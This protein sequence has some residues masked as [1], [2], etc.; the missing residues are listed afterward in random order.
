[1]SK[2]KKW[3]SQVVKITLDPQLGSR[4]RLALRLLA[5]IGTFAGL[6]AH[7]DQIVQATT[8]FQALLAI[9]VVAPTPTP[10][11]TPDPSQDGA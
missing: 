4:V 1:M 10:D 11:P 9:L 5:G 2:F 8:A 6:A 3:I 7:Q